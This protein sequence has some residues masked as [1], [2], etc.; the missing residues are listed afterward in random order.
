MY[1]NGNCLRSGIDPL[2]RKELD[3]VKSIF[4]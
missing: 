2:S 3:P 1:L 4:S